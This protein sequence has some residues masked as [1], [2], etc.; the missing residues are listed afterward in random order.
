MANTLEFDAPSTG[1][2][3]EFDAPEQ[4]QGPR[5]DAIE[6]PTALDDFLV[7]FGNTTIGRQL[8]GAFGGNMRGS[9]VGR[10]MQGMADPGAALVQLGA[11]ATG[12]DDGVNQRI[13]D[14][15]KQYQAARADAGST[16]FDP[17]RMAGNIAITAPVAG[18]GGVP[19]SLAGRVG[20]GAVQGAGF[21]ALQPVTEGDYWSEKGRQVGTGALIGGAAAPVVGAVSRMLSPRASL[22]PDVKTL[23]AAGVKLT[24]G[25]ALGG[26]ASKIEEKM[27]SL[28]IMGDAITA[29]RL[30]GNEQFNKA[31]LDKAVAGIGGKVTKTGAEGLTQVRQQL[32]QAYDDLL[33]KMSINATDPQFVGNVANLRSMVQS[34]PK[35]E[36]RQFDNIITREIEQRMAPNGMLSGQ[37]LKAAQAAIRDKASQ[38]SKS[39]DAYQSQLGQALKQLDAELRGHVSASN[40]QFSKQ[41]SAIDKGYAVF[42]RAQRAGSALG[43]DAGTFTP[44]Q[45]Q[46][47]VKAMDKSK[48]KRAFSEGTAFLQ[49]LSGPAKNVMS[50]RVPDSGTAGRLM[51]G[52]G[53]LAS[54]AVNPAIP[55]ALVGGA[56]A[57]TPAVQNF[58]VALATKRPDQAA[59]LAEMLRKSTPY[60]TAGAAP[61]A[62]RD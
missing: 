60:I 13:A 45:L 58:L 40:P 54:G 8:S 4:P 29:A 23:Q 7:R 2:T 18:V 10:V 20:M 21:S 41:L 36:A 30:R 43:S 56:A 42:K 17:L 25:Q 35:Q 11:N 31:I 15:E 3:L 55:A 37:N 59:K 6:Q 34:L 48:D 16:G 53:G 27:Q 26:T 61:A 22:N 32:G 12:Q 46:N 33:P 14:V 9:A 19:A 5:F 1:R 50:G 38:F 51:L 52:V 62:V 28:P 49:E 57:Y 24:P 47:A 44:A 39:T